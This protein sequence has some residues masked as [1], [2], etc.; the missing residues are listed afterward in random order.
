MAQR[1]E[2]MKDLHKQQ[3]DQNVTKRQGGH[4]PGPWKIGT[5]IDNYYI[6]PASDTRVTIL[7]SDQLEIEDAALIAAAPDLLETLTALLQ[8]VKT[9]GHSNTER[10]YETVDYLGEPTL[11]GKYHVIDGKGINMNFLTNAE[12]AIAKATGVKRTASS[13]S[14]TKEEK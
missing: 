14:A 2:N 12:E 11:D 5:G 8:V 7:S 3:H 4:T 9:A 1:G 10:G 13:F 6:Y